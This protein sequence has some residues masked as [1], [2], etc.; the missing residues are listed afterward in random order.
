MHSILS[1]SEIIYGLMYPRSNCM[2]STTRRLVPIPLESSTV[3]TPSVPTFSIASA[4][5]S[6]TVLSAAEI[7]ATCAIASLVC[8]GTDFFLISSTK[9]VTACSIPFFNTI[10]FAPAATFLI[11]S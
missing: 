11:P 5:R 7:A 10:G 3:I 4:I 2:P 8:T 6:P 9:A 1:A